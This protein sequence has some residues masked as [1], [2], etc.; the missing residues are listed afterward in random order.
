M[1]FCGFELNLKG[2]KDKDLE[3]RSSILDVLTRFKIDPFKFQ[4]LEYCFCKEIQIL[5]SVHS[6]VISIVDY[7]N[8]CCNLHV[9]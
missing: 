1:I 7:A 8:K 6:I 2:L 9:K 4:M 3:A 5:C